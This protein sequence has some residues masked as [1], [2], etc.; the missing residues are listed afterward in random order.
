MNFDVLVM[1]LYTAT[2]VHNVGYS[3]D[4]AIADATKIKLAYDSMVT[5]R[6]ANRN[7]ARST[8]GVV[9]VGQGV[10]GIRGSSSG[11]LY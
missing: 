6:T 11:T 1:N 8:Q 7:A 2:R 10:V 3:V 4:Q 5:L 9:S